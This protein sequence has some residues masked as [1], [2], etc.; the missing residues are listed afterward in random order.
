MCQSTEGTDHVLVVYDLADL[1]RK[2]VVLT[3]Q[4]LK[5]C[6]GRSSL[7]VCFWYSKIASSGDKS[8]K[9]EQ[10]TSLTDNTDCSRISWPLPVSGLSINE[11][12]MN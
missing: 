8:D 12:Y 7:I 6:L 1:Q 4:K 3:F 5:G 9:D 2:A 11:F 10:L